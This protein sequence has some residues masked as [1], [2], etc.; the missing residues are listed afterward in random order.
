MF[1]RK[2]HFFQ[3][4]KTYAQSICLQRITSGSASIA[5]AK[6]EMRREVAFVGR[7]AERSFTSKKIRQ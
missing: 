4:P 3:I 6:G 2:S 1:L 5:S 7:S